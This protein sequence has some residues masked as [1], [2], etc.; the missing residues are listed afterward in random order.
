MFKVF[1]IL[2]NVIRHVFSA[3]DV[4]V[5]GMNEAGYRYEYLFGNR[6]VLSRFIAIES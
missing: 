1:F 2:V 5:D 3:V 6:I 4:Y